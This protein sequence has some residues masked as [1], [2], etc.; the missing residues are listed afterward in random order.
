MVGAVLGLGV[1]YRRWKVAVCIMIFVIGAA[2]WAIFTGGSPQLRAATE[3]NL[4]RIV[5]VGPTLPSGDARFGALLREAF[6]TS[7]TNQ[8]D[9]S[10]IEQNRAAIVAFGIAVGQSNI[11]RFIGLKTDSVLVQNGVR[12]PH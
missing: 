5:A 2:M 3:E 10:T 8:A 9:L 1:L 11:A 6:A 7:E 4:R 12:A